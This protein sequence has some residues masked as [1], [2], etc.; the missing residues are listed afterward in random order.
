[1]FLF[2][3]PC[4]LGLLAPPLLLLPRRYGRVQIPAHFD[5]FGLGLRALALGPLRLRLRL[6]PGQRQ[7]PGFGLGRFAPVLGSQRGLVGLLLRDLALLDSRP[8]LGQLAAQPARLRLCALLGRLAP[9]RLL[10]CRR[11]LL[12]LALVAPHG[13]GPRQRFFGFLLALLDRLLGRLRGALLVL[14]LGPGRLRLAGPLDR[15]PARLAGFACCG[16]FTL[17]RLSGRLRPRLLP[18][19]RLPGSLRRH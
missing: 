2:G 16:F 12:L 10:G 17:P 5:H 14:R 13:L 3:R 15:L 8:R 9:A 19:P 7:S 1:P 11:D 18:L 6:L 4:A